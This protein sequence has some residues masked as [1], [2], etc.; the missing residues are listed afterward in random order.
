M[1]WAAWTKPEHLR[2]WFTPAPWTV[3]DCEID[4]RPGGCSDGH[5][6]AGGQ[7]FPTTSAAISK[8]FPSSAWSGPMPCCRVTVP[9]ENPFFTA[10]ITME[11]QGNGTHYTASP[12]PR[13]S[14]TKVA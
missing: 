5:A 12:P 2:E 8:S 6:V 13:P 14:R 4:L 3:V 7:E 11:P 10:V 1:V 9:R